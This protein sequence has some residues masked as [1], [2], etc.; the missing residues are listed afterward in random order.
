LDS[1][2][3]Y[4]YRKD[5]DFLRSEYTKVDWRR[6]KTATVTEV[7]KLREELEQLWAK[8]KEFEQILSKIAE[9]ERK[10]VSR[11]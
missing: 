8:Q 5:L 9:E 1:D 11:E 10:P 4:F 2:E 7:T 3:A 6:E